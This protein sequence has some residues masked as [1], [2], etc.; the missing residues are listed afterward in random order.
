MRRIMIVSLD[1][2]IFFPIR[3]AWVFRSASINRVTRFDGLFEEIQSSRP[4]I[5]YFDTEVGNPD[6]IIR[7][8]SQREETRHIAFLL[9]YPED[10]SIPEHHRSTEQ[11]PHIDFL[12]KPLRV[13]TIRDISNHILANVGWYLHS[14]RMFVISDDHA[15]IHK[16]RS[17]W[18][19]DEVEI[20]VSR[21]HGLL[22]DD[23][24]TFQPDIVI[25]DKQSIRRLAVDHYDDLRALDSTRH[26]PLLLV[27]HS[28]NRFVRRLVVREFDL[29]EDAHSIALGRNWDSL[30]RYTRSLIIANPNPFRTLR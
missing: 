30:K 5:I 25:L 16:I 9:V 3:R 17:F 26:I 29:V 8:T 15:F 12:Q 6:E 22:L 28:D 24:E 14:V 20:E 11:S 27:S 7:D 21:E 13:E 23:I 19:S 4:D 10:I 1:T 18:A 2:D